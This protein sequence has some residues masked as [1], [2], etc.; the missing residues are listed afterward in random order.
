MNILVT[1]AAGFLGQALASALSTDPNISTLTL[2]DIIEPPSPSPPRRTS[3]NPNVKISRVAADLT[4]NATVESLFTKDLTHIYLLHGLMSGAS[5][6]NLPLGLRINI[7]SMRLILDHLREH[8]PGIIIVFPSSCAIFGPQPPNSTDPVTELT[9]PRPGSSYGSQKLITEVLLND[10]SRRG[11][12][13]VRI[14]RL[15]TIIVRPGKPSGAASSFCS[16]IIREPLAG[17]PSTLPVDPEFPIWFTST[18]AVVR[19]LIHARDLPASVFKEEKCI[20]GRVINL[21]GVTATSKQMLG[22]LEKVGEKEVRELVREERSEE[23][24]KIVYG[25]PFRFDTSWA[26]ELGFVGGEQE[27]V[28]GWAEGVLREY[29]EDYGGSIG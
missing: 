1:G 3:Q 4:A 25:W 2:T 6:A 16:G 13:D 15:P 23:V 19:N 17:L 29:L 22:A 10:F 8:N 5:E 12:L 11:L 20:W 18:R 7:D 14:L 21:P 27:D 24:E 9:M 28:E 26:R